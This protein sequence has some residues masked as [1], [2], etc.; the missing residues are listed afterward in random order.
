[1]SLAGDPGDTGDSPEWRVDSCSPNPPACLRSRLQL[2]LA[3]IVLIAA[4][5][6][7]ARKTGP[8][9]A[10]GP[11]LDPANGVWSMARSSSL[12]ATATGAVPGLGGD[13]RVVYDDRSVPHIFAATET[14]AYRALGYVV[15][16]DRLFQM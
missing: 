12:P 10:L 2:V 6:V 8:V 13:V 9:P 3:I 7:G 14:D 15:A 11:F 16:R 4:L 1:M 5:T